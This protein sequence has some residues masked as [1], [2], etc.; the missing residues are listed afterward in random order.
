MRHV[1]FNGST[2]K[3]PLNS[4][5]FRDFSLKNQL[6]FQKNNVFSTIFRFQKRLKHAALGC[7]HR[8]FSAPS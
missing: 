4:M 6:F 8:Q 3:N 2:P 1:N 7:V 5:G